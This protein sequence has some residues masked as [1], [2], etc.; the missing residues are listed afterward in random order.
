[1]EENLARILQFTL[2]LL[3]A[4]GVALWFGLAVWAYRDITARTSNAVAQIFATLLVA[5][6]F[7]PGAVV[8]LLL[9]PRETLADS[10]QRSIE[11][12]YLAQEL[13]SAPAC[14]T[15]GTHIRDEFLF[16]SECGTALRRNCQACGRL[17]DLDWKMCPFCGVAQPDWSAERQPVTTNGHV[18][19]HVEALAA[20]SGWSVDVESE[21]IP[22]PA[23]RR[24]ELAET[25][26]ER[27][28]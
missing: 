7:V 27:S 6:G 8:Y 2:A 5:L 19:E 21:P 18:V 26:T 10:A 20:D 14:P 15:C 13:A 16:C 4:F 25:A 23:P 3:A 12:E 24:P 9:R 28:D 1:V 11:E 22:A 17:V